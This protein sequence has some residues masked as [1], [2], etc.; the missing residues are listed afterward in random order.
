MFLD[1]G[2]IISDETFCTESNY[3]GKVPEFSAESLCLRQGMATSDRW[4]HM[5]L[6]DHVTPVG[7]V[8]TRSIRTASV[9]FQETWCVYVPQI[10]KQ[11]KR[12]TSKTEG[13]ILTPMEPQSGVVYQLKCDNC[14]KMY[15]GKTSRS[16]GTRYK[17]HTAGRHPR[18]A[19]GEHLDNTGHKCSP[20]EAKILDK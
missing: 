16:L 4:C 2:N 6:L 11:T 13:Q 7:G 1:S 20:K 5:T 18:T 3:G 19:M 15:I 9:N 8:H 14:D 12:D 17:K 10:N